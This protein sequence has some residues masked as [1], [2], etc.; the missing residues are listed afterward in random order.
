M[1]NSVK[2]NSADLAKTVK[3][4]VLLCCRHKSHAVL[5]TSYQPKSLKHC[6]AAFAINAKF[7]ASPWDVI[8]NAHVVLANAYPMNSPRRRFAARAN[9]AKSAPSHWAAVTNS[10]DVLAPCLTSPKVRWGAPKEGA[11]RVTRGLRTYV[12]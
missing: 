7:A 12:R 4:H 11:M 8:A 3:R 6:I 1:C 2:C 5:A 10:T 9:T